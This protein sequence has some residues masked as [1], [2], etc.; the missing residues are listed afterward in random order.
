MTWM[1]ANL[2]RHTEIKETEI[3]V[4]S[5]CGHGIDLVMWTVFGSTLS[6]FHLCCNSTY[7][8]P[9]CPPVLKPDLGPRNIQGETNKTEEAN[10]KDR[11]CFTEDEMGFSGTQR[12]KCQ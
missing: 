7:F 8:P 4:V 3:P 12:K 11:N 5:Q 6:V 9:L 2:H 1:T 10:K